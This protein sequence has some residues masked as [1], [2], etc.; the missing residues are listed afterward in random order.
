VIEAGLFLDDQEI[1]APGYA[2]VE[3]PGTWP[4]TVRW[5]K[6]GKDWGRITQVGLF[7]DGELREILDISSGRG[8]KHLAA[9]VVHISKPRGF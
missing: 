7:R 1:E 3:L 9:I 2:R 6:P 5:N 8:T 4:V